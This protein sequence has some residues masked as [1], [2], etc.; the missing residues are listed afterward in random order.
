VGEEEPRYFN[1]QDVIYLIQR[2]PVVSLS[3]IGTATAYLKHIL[4]IGSEMAP[5]L[6]L[7]P[8]E[9][10]EELEFFYACLTGLGVLNEQ[11]LSDLVN[12]FSWRGVVWGCWLSSLQPTPSHLEVLSKIEM[13]LPDNQWLIDL[14]LSVNR[15]E[16]PH[17]DH[18]EV[19]DLID[20]CCTLIEGLPRPKTPMRPAPNETELIV[21]EQERERI[22]QLYRA[23]GADA[24]RE[25]IG[26]T[27]SHRHFMAHE[28]WRES[29]IEKLPGSE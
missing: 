14:A 28:R 23:H 3:R 6:A 17:P 11:V 21:M 26:K 2:G 20:Q 8:K 18:A 10:M 13:E 4:Q 12:H 25:F 22:R 5:M 9:R 1:E 29:T 16:E 27:Q 7:F 19:V 15:G 24:A